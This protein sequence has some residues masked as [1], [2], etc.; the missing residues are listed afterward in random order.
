MT[1]ASAGRYFY[2]RQLI[3]MLINNM[4][5]HL[6]FAKEN[7]VNGGDNRSE[8]MTFYVWSK[9]AKEK[10]HYEKK[11]ILFVCFLQMVIE[12]V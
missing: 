1:V 4:Y 5:I 8:C 10:H 6:Y 11:I 3:C 12:E 2:S 9:T 7:I